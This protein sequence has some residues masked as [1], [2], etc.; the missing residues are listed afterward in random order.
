MRKGFLM[1][2]L[3]DSLLRKGRH[4]LKMVC[5]PW[6]SLKILLGWCASVVTAARRITT[7]IMEPWI[8]GLAGE[9]RAMPT[10]EFLLRWR[11]NL[12][13][14]AFSMKKNYRSQM[15]PGFFQ[16]NITRRRIG[17]SFTI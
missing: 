13:F 5:V 17:S 11:M 15:T 10:R 3:K 8:A 7:P 16:G 1:G 12:K 4:L 2:F 6:G 14:V 9:H